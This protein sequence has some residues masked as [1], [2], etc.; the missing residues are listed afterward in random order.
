MDDIVNLFVVLV[1]KS[2]VFAALKYIPF[3]GIVAPLGINAVA[4]AVLEKLALVPVNAPVNLPV[5][6]TSNV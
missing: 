2:K 5:P 1:A 6:L 3:A 4:V